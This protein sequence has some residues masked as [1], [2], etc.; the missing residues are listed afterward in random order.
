MPPPGTTSSYHATACPL[1]DFDEQCSKEDDWNVDTGLYYNGRGDKASVDLA[2][3]YQQTRLRES[4]DNYRETWDTPA[5][6][7]KHTK[8]RV[9]SIAIYMREDYLLHLVLVLRSTLK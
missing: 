4:R 5:G 9:Q 3:M 7:E 1:V 6:F 2:D 8:V